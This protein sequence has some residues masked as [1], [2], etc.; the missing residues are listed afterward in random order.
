MVY[1]VES[2]FFKQGEKMT[3]NQPLVSVFLPY[4]N[5]AKFLRQS[6]E[7]VL[8]QNYQNF[9]LILCNHATTDNCRKIAHSYKD[10]RI[11][12]VDMLRNEGAGGGLVFEAMFNASSGKYIKTL[13]ADDMLTPDC[14]ATMV[15]F[16]ENNPNIDFAFGNVEYIDEEGQDMHD[17]WFH[18]RPFFSIDDKEH[19][20]IRKYASGKATLPYIGNISKREIF[21]NI[22]INKTFVMMFDISLWLQLLCHGHRIALINKTI[23]N[24]RIHSDQ[25]SA[26]G[27]EALCGYICWFEG[28][29]FYP[30]LMDINDVNLAKQVFPNS[31]YVNKLK[32]VCDIPFFV[33]HEMF[34]TQKPLF[35]I[36]LTKMLNDDKTREHLMKTFNFGVKELR[37]L[38]KSD[39]HINTPIYPK[40]IKQHVYWSTPADLTVFG[41]IFLLF[42]RIFKIVT[43]DTVRH[44][45]KKRYSL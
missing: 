2:R 40:G 20:L 39:F 27:K 3:K 24:Y 4:Y 12:H 11:K 6:I 37:E 43:L 32:N 15:D 8:K 1:I 34:N 33:A 9:E 35:D 42:R 21:N 5:D 41:L 30:Y 10:K 13:C 19:D 28:Y 7:S 45:R 38:R 16:M 23:G 26:I 22:E 25:V 18:Q 17:D 29:S 31:K 36:P 14:L 44:K